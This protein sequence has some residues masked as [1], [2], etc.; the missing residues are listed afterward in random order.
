MNTNYL[1]K[2][3]K[4]ELLD[5]KIENPTFKL[6]KTSEIGDYLPLIIK[7]RGSE[8]VDVENVSI[9]VPNIQTIYGLKFTWENQSIIDCRSFYHTPKISL[10][11]QFAATTNKHA[12]AACH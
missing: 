5:S 8:E 7:R 3:C 6:F 1:S 11:E 4:K 9:D 12:G 10:I 2:Q